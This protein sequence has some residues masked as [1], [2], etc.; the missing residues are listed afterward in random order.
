MPNEE[1][2]IVDRGTKFGALF[3]G[4]VANLEPLRER[5]EGALCDKRTGGSLDCPL[6]EQLAEVGAPTVLIG[7]VEAK[8]G[9]MYY[10]NITLIARHAMEAT[11]RRAAISEACGEV[12]TARACPML[13]SPR[14]K[15]PRTSSARASAGEKL[16]CAKET[17]KPAILRRPFGWIHTEPT[18]RRP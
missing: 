6:I 11:D 15:R 7:F 5:I 2:E 3:R 18:S 14:S 4:S 1:S 17:P 8:S 9:D 10:A 13:M 12:A 16:A